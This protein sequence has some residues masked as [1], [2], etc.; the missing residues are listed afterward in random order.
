LRAVIETQTP[1]MYLHFTL[2]PGAI[3]V[4]PAKKNTTLY[5]LE[6]KACWAGEERAGDKQ[7]VLFAQ[8]GER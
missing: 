7:M 5:V 4:Q 8:D 2:Q 3:M 6:G 1:I